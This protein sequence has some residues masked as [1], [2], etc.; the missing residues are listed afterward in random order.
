MTYKTHKHGITSTSDHQLFELRHLYGKVIGKVIYAW[1]ARPFDTKDYFD[2]KF[3][4][5]GIRSE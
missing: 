3:I 4:V 1:G 2:H 5:R